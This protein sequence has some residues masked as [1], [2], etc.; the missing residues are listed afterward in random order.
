M[1]ITTIKGLLDPYAK[2]T[3]LKINYTK[4]QMMPINVSDQRIS[5]LAAALGCEVGIMP[6]THGERFDASC[7]QH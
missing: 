4:P 5:E 6:F 2:A 1:I 3:G 7:G